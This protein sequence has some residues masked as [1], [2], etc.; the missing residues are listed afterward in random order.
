[1]GEGATHRAAEEGGHSGTDLLRPE[2]AAHESRP[3]RRGVIGVELE[4]AAAPV[5]GDVLAA[6]HGDL[7]ARQLERP[8]DV[9]LL[10]PDPFLRQGLERAP[11]LV[12]AIQHPVIHREGEDGSCG[13]GGDERILG[14]D[15]LAEHRFSG[16]RVEHVHF[17]RRDEQNAARVNV[18]RED[19]SVHLEPLLEAERPRVDVQDVQIILGALVRPGAVVP[20]GD[21]DAGLRR[22]VVDDPAEDLDPLPL[23]AP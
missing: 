19:P 22:I 9:V 20:G 11:V 14:F 7:L 3:A 21:H 18:G 12:E 15:R 8:R 6:D 13:L 17:M 2:Q 4:L 23:L 1:M 10:K 16:G 5:N